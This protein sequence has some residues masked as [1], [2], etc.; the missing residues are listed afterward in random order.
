MLHHYTS[1]P[2]ACGIFSTDLRYGHY[3]SQNHGVIQ[4][5]VWLTTSLN[6]KEHGLLTGQKINNEKDRA[7]A[8]KIQGKQL[9][10]DFTQDKTQIRIDI[11]E[12]DLEKLDLTL[13]QKTPLS[14]WQGLVEYEKFSRI[15]LGEDKLY[16]QSIGLSCFYDIAALSDSE[17]KSLIHRKQKNISTWRLHFGGIHPNFFKKVRFKQKNGE[18]VP[19]DFERHGRKVC[20]ESGFQYLSKEVLEEYM[21]IIPTATE[22]EI[23]LVAAFCSDPSE[24]AH[25]NFRSGSQE[26]MI[27]LDDNMT[28]ESIRGPIPDDIERV[29]ELLAANKKEA[30]AA[31]EQAVETYYEYNPG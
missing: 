4:P 9:R 16:R 11:D 25:I 6:E 21:E 31:W 8:A 26:W 5:L 19:F 29:R 22:Y 13:S 28:Y 14:Q 23:P 1:V 17:A 24:R 15:I 7:Y 27:K 2:L 18:Y 30:Q 3:Q 12:K 20:A 10:N